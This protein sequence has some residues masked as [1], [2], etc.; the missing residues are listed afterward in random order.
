VYDDTTTTIN[1]YYVSISISIKYKCII[2]LVDFIV[3]K[4]L[5][6]DMSSMWYAVLVLVLV[7]VVIY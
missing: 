6:I 3:V 2:L 5:G 1:Y 4:S 7:G